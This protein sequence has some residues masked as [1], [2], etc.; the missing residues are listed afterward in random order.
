[1]KHGPTSQ[2]PTCIMVR[3]KRLSQT[4]GPATSLPDLQ[5]LEALWI[6]HGTGLDAK[7]VVHTW[8][9]PLDK[10]LLAESVF[11]PRPAGVDT[12]L[13]DEHIRQLVVQLR[14]TDGRGLKPIICIPV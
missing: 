6:A 13:Q 1:M 7:A 12:W 3:S 2:E 4:G 5:R 14:E 11:Q 8:R 9:L 10:I